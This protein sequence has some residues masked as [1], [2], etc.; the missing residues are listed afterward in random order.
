MGA[1]H[2]YSRNEVV[3]VP[4]ATHVD[5]LICASHARAEHN[6]REV[7]KLLTFRTEGKSQR[8]TDML[9]LVSGCTKQLDE[10]ATD[11]EKAQF[12]SVIASLETRSGVS[13]QRAAER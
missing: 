11:D 7:Q 2:A 8:K 9:H 13:C 1:I 4:V 6:L 12:M 10:S 3:E 5:D